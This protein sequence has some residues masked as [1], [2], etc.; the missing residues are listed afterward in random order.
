MKNG[1]NL[2]LVSPCSFSMAYLFVQLFLDSFHFFFFQ[3]RLP[4]KF[5]VVVGLLA[6]SKTTNK[7]NYKTTRK[8]PTDR[9]SSFCAS[10]F[11]FS[12]F[13]NVKSFFDYKAHTHTHTHGKNIR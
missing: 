2:P 10:I 8:A 13:R 11:G 1:G 6:R 7:Q 4:S 9:S 12:S 5:T 3:I